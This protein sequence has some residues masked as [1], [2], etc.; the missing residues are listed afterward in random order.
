MKKIV[1]TIT[2]QA[3]FEAYNRTSRHTYR[4]SDPEL[5]EL[6]EIPTVTDL[7]RNLDLAPSLGNKV[8]LYRLLSGQTKARVNDIPDI[9]K[10]IIL[11]IVTDPEFQLAQPPVR[12][13]TK[14]A[15][16]VTVAPRK[17]VNYLQLLNELT[18]RIYHQLTFIRHAGDYYLN[19]L[20][21]P[22][23]YQQLCHALR[24]SG[25]RLTAKDMVVMQLRRYIIH[26]GLPY[27]G[28]WLRNA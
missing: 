22:S 16:N 4:G 9:S 21:A 24:T 8:A 26:Y 19:E 18:P 6:K 14:P 7:L 1:L 5:L 17:T 27:P 13:E 15:P 23:E 20:L 3:I 12:V 10:N 25:A 11:L 2:K 28:A